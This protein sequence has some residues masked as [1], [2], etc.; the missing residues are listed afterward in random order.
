MKRSAGLMRRRTERRQCSRRLSDDLCRGSAATHRV[1]RTTC[2][3]FTT[4]FMIELA[5]QATRAKTTH[6]RQSMFHHNPTH[7]V[8]QEN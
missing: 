1:I 4:L 5:L 8:D 2:Q 7:V 3:S 6:P